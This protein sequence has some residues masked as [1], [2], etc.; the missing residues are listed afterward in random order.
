VINNIVFCCV[1]A[2]A[3]SGHLDRI[4][5]DTLSW[6]LCERQKLDDGGLNG[7]PEKLSDVCYSWWVLSAMAIMDR[8]H[9]IDRD[10]LHQFI[11]KCQDPENGGIADKPDNM[12]D[13]F[14]TFFGI[15]GLSL[16]RAEPNLKMIDPVYALSVDV[17]R[18]V[19]VR[20]TYTNR[21]RE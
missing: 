2:L 17:L 8:L 20:T 3:I 21:F 16:L 1:A 6:W 14:H 7:R 5:K 13:V 19:G 12:V 4:N 18:R 11:L 9:W 15:G 10:R